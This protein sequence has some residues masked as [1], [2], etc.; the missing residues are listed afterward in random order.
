MPPDMQPADKRGPGAHPVSLVSLAKVWPTI[1][2]SIPA[3]ER[4]LARRTLVVP[5]VSACDQDLA[6]VITQLPG[7][8]EF[9]I[10]DGVIIKETTLIGRSALELLG[11]GDV[12][13]PPLT[14]ARQ[15]E[16]RAVS[17]YVAHGRVSLAAIEARFRQAVRRWPGIADSLLDR[18][19]RQTHRTSMHLAMLHLARVEDRIT[20]LFADLAERFGRVTPDG[21]VIE[22]PLTHD[23]IGGLVGSRRPTVTLA[24]HKLAAERLLERLH[25][26]HWRLDRRVISA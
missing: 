11:T 17:R 13:A 26:D 6:Q 20:A 16:S 18:L 24:L 7:A 14:A 19:A 25:N 21:I 1:L 12:L 3:E 8:S 23:L 9:L 2:E 10:V 4:P 15:L 22:L 5:V